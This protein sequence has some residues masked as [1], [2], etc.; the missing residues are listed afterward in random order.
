MIQ[1]WLSAYNLKY[2]RTV[3]YMLQSSEYKVHDYLKWF[4]RLKSFN[5]VE[6]RKKLEK[7]QKSTLLLY[8]AW[9]IFTT[10]FILI[11]KL[12]FFSLYIWALIIFILT[13]YILAYGIIA[14]L[15]LIKVF[16]QKPIEY[17]TI[18]RAHAKLKNHPALKIGIA[19]SFGKT[20]MREILKT[21]LMQG[22]KVATVPHNHNTLLGISNFIESLEGDEEVLIFE[23]GEYYKGDIREMCELVN[24]S[25]GIITGVNEAHLEKFKNL[26][27]TAST[28]FELADW[29]VGKTV[30]VNGENNLAKEKSSTD[31]ILYTREGIND[32]KVT[33]A[34]TYLN[35]T[36]FDLIKNGK[37]HVFK[38][39][40]LGLHQI[41]PILVAIDIALKLGMKMPNIKVSVENT[42]AFD[43]RLEPR[44]DASGVITI[45][46]S[47]NGNPDGVRVIIEFLASI[48]GHR[49][50][51]VTPGLVEMGGKTEEVHREIGRQ[52]AEAKIEKVILVKNSVTPFI[53]QG[54]IESK[55][56][57]EVVWFNDSLTL[58]KSLP[59]LTTTGDV[60]LL[61]NDWPDQYY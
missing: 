35:G 58:F 14:P 19:G 39:E 2:P 28:I 52:L 31:H 7:T 38:S 41:G 34:K 30:Y 5:N 48:H 36:Y 3:V 11:L 25:I 45:D 33:N 21:V 20:T 24:P 15:F 1:K 13:P 53:E 59:H 43:H 27:T 16:V 49:R 4:A 26:D 37:K 55:Y 32:L 56:N 60:V 42:R 50:I 8:I 6:V 9:A 47:Y 12:L 29:L 17:F 54:L 10:T 61:Q 22:K 18:K 40:L 46:D 44:T 51:Y 57:G 23:L